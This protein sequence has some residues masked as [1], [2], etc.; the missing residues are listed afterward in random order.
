MIHWYAIISSE[1]YAHVL[2][3]DLPA[4]ADMMNSWLN[5]NLNHQSRQ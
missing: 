4:K 2:F 5:N 3:S 1:Q